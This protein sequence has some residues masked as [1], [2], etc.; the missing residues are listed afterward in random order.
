MYVSRSKRHKK[1]AIDRLLGWLGFTPALPSNRMSLRRK[2]VSLMLAALLLLQTIQIGGFMQH[3]SA[4]PVPVPDTV[5]KQV[6]LLQGSSFGNDALT[7]CFS[8]PDASC[9][10]LLTAVKNDGSSTPS[11]TGEFEA[12]LG[13]TSYPFTLAYEWEIDDDIAANGGTYTFAL[14]AALK[15]EADILNV[16]I[17]SAGSFSV[18]KNSKTITITFAAQDGLDPS[19]R[20]K[21]GGM[22]ISAWLEQTTVIENNEIEVRI[23]VSASAT[24][25]VNLPVDLGNPAPNI[26]KAL[27]GVDRT[28]NTSE[29]YWTVDVNRSLTA[30]GQAIVEDTLPS[31]LELVPSSIAVHP[32]NVSMN[33]TATEGAALAAAAYIVDPAAGVNKFTV[34]LGSINSAYRIKFTTKVKSD[35]VIPENPPKSLT[36]Q[37]RLLDGAVQKASASANVSV[38][39]GPTL[40]KVSG[41]YLPDSDHTV[42]WTLYFNFGQL[43]HTDP[44]LT[45]ILPAGHELV[46]GTMTVEAVNVAA[47]G[48]A[49]SV[50]GAPLAAGTGYTLTY[51]ASGSP[52]DKDD[53]DLQLN[54]TIDDAYRIVYKTKAKDI[55]PVVKSETKSNSYTTDV[56]AGG[57]NASVLYQQRIIDKDGSITNYGAKEMTWTIALNKNGYRFEEDGADKVKLVDTFTNRGLTLIP[58]SLTVT[59]QGG[60]ALMNGVD[61]VLT[62]TYDG[63]SRESG[64]EI[65]FADGYTFD[66]PHTIA[67]KTTF[68]YEEYPAAGS[69][70]LSNY[71]FPNTGVFSWGKIV[72]KATGTTTLLGKDSQSNAH[73]I[74]PNTNTRY[75]GYKNGSYDARN[76]NTTWNVLFNYHNESV[77]GAT[78]TDTLQSGQAL[79]AGSI[80]VKSQ[81]LA[82]NGNLS[83]AA[84]LTEDTHF[85]VSYNT[86]GANPV[87]TITFIGTITGPHLITF[88]TTLEGKLV[89]QQINNTA[90]FTSS[91]ALYRATLQASVSPA[92]GNEF[93]VK[94]FKQPD[95]G[96]L[97]LAE[98]SLWINRSLSKLN[99]IVVED[100]PDQY[101]TLVQNSFQLF[102]AVPNVANPTQDS[103]FTLTP[104][105]AANYE[106]EFL[107]ATP[108]PTGHLKF[109][110]TIDAPDE[111]A[112]KLVYRSLLA[113]GVGNNTTNQFSMSGWGS[114]VTSQPAQHT[115]SVNKNSASGFSFPSGASYR[116]SVKIVKQADD[117]ASLKLENAIFKIK[118][119]FGPDTIPPAPT[120]ENGEVTFT[121]LPFDVYEIV[122]VT[123]PTGYKLDT[124]AHEIVINS[125]TEQTL[126]LTNV[127][128]TGRIGNYVWLDRDRDGIQ[129]TGEA[130]INGLTVNLYKSG[131]TTIFKTTTTA[132]GGSGEPGHYLFTDLEPGNYV[133]EFNWPVDYELTQNVPGNATKDSNPLDGDRKTAAITINRANGFEDLTIDLGLVA[134]GEIGDY[135]W[136]DRDR[137]GRQDAAELGINGIEA[138]LFKETGGVRTEV[139]RTLTANH[140]YDHTPGYYLFE[141]LL[142]GDYY[143]QFV[144]PVSYDKTAEEVGP[145][146]AGD[147]NATDATGLTD[148]IEIGVGNW[149]DHTIDLGLQAKGKIGNY[150]WF[151]SNDNGIQEAGEPG[152]EHIEVKLYDKTGGANVLVETQYTDANGYYLFDHL[153]QSND[154]YVWFQTPSIYDLAKMEEAGSTSAND[155][156]RIQVGGANAGQTINAI[157]IGPAGWENLT[158]D[159]GFTGKGAIGDYVWHDRNRNG[160][161]DEDPM[162]GINGVKVYLY[163]NASTGTPYKTDTTKTEGGNPGYYNFKELPQGTY[164]IRFELPDEYEKTVAESDDD[165]AVGSNAT[166]ATHV[167]GAIKIGETETPYGWVDPSIDLGLVA[168]G[169]IG[170]Y[171]WF[172]RNRNGIQDASEAG[173]NGIT[174]RLYKNSA[175]GP[176][177]AET[178]TANGPDGKPGY[179]LFDNLASGN[180]YVQIDLDDNHEV[181]AEEQGS[182]ANA[183]ELDSNAVNAQ[184]MTVA[185]A[186]GDAAPKGWHDPTIDFGVVRKGAIGNY[187]WHDVDYDGKQDEEE[188]YGINGVTVKLYDSSKTLLASTVT[189]DKDGKPGYYL[190]DHLTA[191]NYYVEFVTPLFYIPTRQGADGVTVGQDSNPTL[192]GY[193]EVVAIGSAAPA[194][195]RNMTIDQGFYY[196]PPVFPTPTPTPTPTPEESE[197]PGATPKPTP[198]PA[199]TPKPSPGTATPTPTP[200]TEKTPE[201]TPIDVEVEVPKGGT[202]ET[203]TPPKNGT[204]TVKPGGKVTYTPKPGYTGKDKFSVIVKDKDGNE[205]EFWFDI[206]VE[207]PPLG[208]FEG[209]PDIG[210]LPKTGEESYLM[211]Y[212]IGAAFVAGGIVLRAR[213]KRRNS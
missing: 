10:S 131:E 9:A 140:P 202:T 190:F 30:I 100:T 37:V 134:K 61:Y 119:K 17:G 69:W 20:Q 144:V 167:T 186:I 98:W 56:A 201:D 142:G 65:V 150:V 181:T 77:T 123:A 1:P 64:F 110:L 79:V 200:Q 26:S 179:Y 194:V 208:G 27:A 147:S 3:T 187:V 178:V 97:R 25:V 210:N 53:F 135:V 171:V 80:V 170:N 166:N 103:H 172:D 58:L 84:T 174:L 152:I 48:S 213:G 175:A 71:S 36:N 32:L 168:Q 59:P 38:Q 68:D 57:T 124:T 86:S 87:L 204:V 62:Q 122:E 85:T 67:Y 126:T 75:N 196:I 24:I 151:D 18:D 127:V 50:I 73:T 185:I 39:R 46:P 139:A 113:V 209:T 141:H 133:V 102:K 92:Y 21:K 82:A 164:Y 143:V 5:I 180:Y 173:L 52:T 33:G 14:P 112:Y 161:Q 108:T 23:P 4:A 120:D 207:E 136:L 182:G 104:V 176:V 8:S 211:L 155:S 189:A 183:H 184:N 76:K 197:K 35:A 109:K 192:G 44:V 19:A 13:S 107:D 121:N 41:S 31:D 101:Q 16:P 138:I 117:D 203:G 128:N 40:K 137:D 63:A 66:K 162:H 148:L 54:G 96:G 42:T 83:D 116:G 154:Y 149:V 34:D 6:L 94:Q 70:S 159:L 81:T 15:L 206:D 74:T 212:L 91:N 99:E 205:E 111:A 90:T 45:D 115:F 163:R 95:P 146:A 114:S 106:L 156:N 29:V 55:A 158:V 165:S 72:D 43:E 12:A 51:T 125:T 88:K 195:W 28:V 153:V 22:Q 78:V 93:I 198:T 157:P 199:P 47:D 129:D 105:P 130:G 145:G 193:T 60:A 160:I 118:P 7:A 177:Y 2:S 89:P 49:G 132:A 11:Y 169:T 188:N 191:G